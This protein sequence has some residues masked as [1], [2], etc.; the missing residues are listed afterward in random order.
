MMF[1]DIKGLNPGVFY[2]LATVAEL[3]IIIIKTLTL[4]KN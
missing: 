4:Q 1:D 3:E 2:T